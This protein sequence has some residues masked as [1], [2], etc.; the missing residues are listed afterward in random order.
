MTVILS[1]RKNN[2]EKIWKVIRALR[3]FSIEEVATLTELTSAIV[4]VYVHQLLGAGY[5]KQAGIRKEASGRKRLYR[6]TKNTGPKAPVPCRCI[7]DPNIDDAAIAD[8]EVK[9]V[10]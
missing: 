3:E 9:D 10:A 7:Y 1:N 5:V 6:L 4:S 2:R 8:T